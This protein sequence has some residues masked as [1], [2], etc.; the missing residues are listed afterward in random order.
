[1]QDMH[2]RVAGSRYV[3]LDA[4]HISN[5]E[6]PQEFNRALSEFLDSVG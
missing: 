4:A 5:L 1:M 2:R 6:R 3:E